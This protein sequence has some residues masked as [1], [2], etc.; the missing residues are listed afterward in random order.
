[1]YN[2]QISA[3]SLLI[4]ESRRIAQVLLSDPSGDEWLREIERNNVLQKKPRTALRQ[5]QLIRN[6]LE[7]LDKE[8]WTFIASGEVELVAQTLFASAIRH[9]Q[10][11]ADFMRDVYWTDIRKLEVSLSA[12]QWQ[13]FLAECAH[14][15]ESVN[16]WALST[17]AKLFEVIVRILAEAKYLDSTRRKKLTPP[18]LHPTL[19]AYLKRRGNHKTLACMGSR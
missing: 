5:A 10:L 2:A 4:P 1:M 9:S 18:M 3:G 19:V 6:R 12:N 8:G 11:L 17:R 7:T 14:R 13:D 15:D 16:G